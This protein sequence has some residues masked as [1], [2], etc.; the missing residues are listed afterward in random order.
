MGTNNDRH[1]LANLMTHD[2]MTA[3]KF[4]ELGKKKH[5]IGQVSNMVGKLMRNTGIDD[6]DRMEAQ[7][8]N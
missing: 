4:Y 5:Q 1:N 2:E 6:S 8:G 3:G 7:A